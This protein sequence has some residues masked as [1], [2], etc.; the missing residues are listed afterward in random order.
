MHAATGGDRAIAT[1]NALT[2]HFWSRIVEGPEPAITNVAWA[3][4]VR[5]GRALHALLGL[6]FGVAGHQ[7]GP[8]LRGLRPPRGNI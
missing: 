8:C 5:P 2:L 6:A 4:Q 1:I 7:H 3:A